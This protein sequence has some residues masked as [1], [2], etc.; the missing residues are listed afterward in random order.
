[1]VVDHRP[2]R[3]F[4]G[5]HPGRRPRGHEPRHP[6]AGRP[7]RPRQRPVAR[8][9]GIPSDRSSW[10][11]FVAARRRRREAGARDHRGAGPAGRGARRRRLP[12]DRLPV[13]VVHGRDDRRGAR[14]QAAAAGARGGR[15]AARRTRHG[16]RSSA[17]SRA[18]AAAACSARTSTTTTATPSATSS[19][20]SRAGSAS[21]T[22]PTTATRSSP[23][24]ATSTSPTWPRCS[25]SP[26]S[27]TPRHAAATVLASGDPA[28]RGPLGARRDPRRHQDLQPQDLRRARRA[29]PGVRLGRLGAQHGRQPRHAVRGRASASRPTSSTSPAVLAGDADRGLAQL[30]AGQGDPVGRAVPPRRVRAGQLRL[31]R[32]HPRRHPRAA[33]PLEARRH[34]GRGRDGRGRRPRVRR[35]ALPAAQ[36]GDDGR[37]GRQPRRGL[38]T[39]DRRP[40]LD[41]R[42]DQAAGVREARR[43][44]GPRSATPTSGATTPTLKFYPG[45]LLRNA[46]AARVVRDRAPA[47]QDRRAGRQGRVADAAPAGQRLLQPRH[48]R[49]LLPGRHP[50]EAV[51]RARRRP[52][53]EL[54][55]HRRG[56][57]ARD[58]PRLRRPGRRST[59]APATST[60]GGPP[61]TS[62]RSR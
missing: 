13:R 24:S 9:G 39:L 36:Q 28:G 32:P 59:T 16:R 37:A 11:P 2:F 56:D 14:S 18:T 26:A 58:R 53:R 42:G 48:Q 6:A 46:A 7:L 55:R 17:S 27:T 10:G 12:Q 60:T 45:E 57:R 40:G 1:M 22:R 25:S 54:R 34:D 3:L 20:S 19:T 31:L 35:A 44:S 43:R 41:E 23:R 5:E 15:L 52:G 50:A 8:R 49:D 51:L 21:P 62:R 47:G 61:T 29:V 33:R 38:P 30:R 4:R